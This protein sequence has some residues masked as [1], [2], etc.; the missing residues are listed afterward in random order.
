[1]SNTILTQVMSELLEDYIIESI[2]RDDDKHDDIINV[3]VNDHDT[4]ENVT[5]IEEHH[6]GT[7][8][9][10]IDE[11]VLSEAITE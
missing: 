6:V 1:M 2:A 4:I 5:D 3:V 9:R 10:N 7:V 8:V 11:D